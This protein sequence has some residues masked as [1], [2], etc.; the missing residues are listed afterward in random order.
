M[1]IVLIGSIVVYF[2]I[3]AIVNG[4]MHRFDTGTFD[5]N[6]RTVGLMVFLWIILVPIYFF[7]LFCDRC[8]YWFERKRRNNL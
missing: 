6:S 1:D 7:C 4:L 2:M 3:G 5:C 8:I